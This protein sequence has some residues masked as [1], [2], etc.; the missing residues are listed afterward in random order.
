[1][2]L[3]VSFDLLLFN[4]L[5]SYIVYIVILC[6]INIWQRVP[7]ILEAVTH[8]TD[9]FLTMQRICNLKTCSSLFFYAQTTGF[10]TKK[11]DKYSLHSSLKEIK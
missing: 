6:W 1:M 9:F 8:S 11:L 3:F 2:W 5:V 4:V 7:P 10:M